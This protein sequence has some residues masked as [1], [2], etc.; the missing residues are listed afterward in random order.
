[1]RPMDFRGRWV[2]VTG[3]SSG[4]GRAMAQ[5]LAREHGAH[6]IAVARRTERLEELRH[7]LKSTGV[8][9]E[10]VTADLAKPDDVVRVIARANERQAHAAV[11]NAGVTHFGAFQEQ[12]WEDFESMLSTNVTSVVRMTTELLKPM[13][14][15]NDGG[16]IM[17]VASMAGLLP[18]PYQTTYSATKAFLVHYGCGLSHELRGRQLSITTYAPGGIDTEMT[19]GERFARLRAWTMPVETAARLGLDAFRRRE[20]LY[21]PGVT[22]RIGA[23]LAKVLPRRLVTA[24]VGSAYRRALDAARTR[25]H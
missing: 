14:Q 5:Q 6:V 2:L 19:S 4:L 21:V 25:A 7:E 18:V 13:E 16:G 11:L 22:N 1:M 24:Q 20:E 9:L 23:A 15:R 12:R 3:A 17:L 8:E 10:P